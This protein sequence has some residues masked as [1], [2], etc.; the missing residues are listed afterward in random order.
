MMNKDILERM[1]DSATPVNE[2][3]ALMSENTAEDGTLYLPSW[4]LFD[5]AVYR[6]QMDWDVLQFEKSTGDF[7]HILESL[8]AIAAHDAEL[9]AEEADPAAILRN[10]ALLEVYHTYYEA[11]DDG[12]FDRARIADIADRL[13]TIRMVEEIQSDLQNGTMPE[14]E[15]PTHFLEESEGVT[16][17]EEERAYLNAYHQH[18][19][20]MAELRMGKG[21]LPYEAHIRGRRLCRLYALGAPKIV[22]R[23]ET[24]AFAAAFMLHRHGVSYET[25]HPEA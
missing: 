7:Y 19:E 10:D 14:E 5:N 1:G 3:L 2:L 6:C 17:S 15:I 11:L 8:R 4:D 12:N 13:D 21:V 23:H 18:L 24:N 25:V 16:V 20:Q 22:V 9:R